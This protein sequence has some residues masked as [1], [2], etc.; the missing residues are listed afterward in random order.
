MEA[1]PAGWTESGRFTIPRQTKID[2]KSGGIWTH[3]VVA[4]GRLYLRDNDL[5]YCFDVKEK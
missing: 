4:N 3:P 1:A 2:R 5:I